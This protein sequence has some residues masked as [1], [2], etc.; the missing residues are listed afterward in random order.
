MQVKKIIE[1]YQCQTAY[2]QRKYFKR[3][4]VKTSKWVNTTKQ[5]QQ[6]TIYKLESTLLNFMLGFHEN[7]YQIKKFAV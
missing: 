7:Q 5:I 3:I 6:I 2:F 4:N 1:E